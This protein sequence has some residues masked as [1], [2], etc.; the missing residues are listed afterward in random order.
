MNDPKIQKS[1]YSPY[2]SF[3][4]FWYFEKK[5]RN[6]REAAITPSKLT[7]ITTVRLPE[8]SSSNNIYSQTTSS[9]V[10]KRKP[11]VNFS[12]IAGSAYQRVPVQA[13]ILFP[14]Q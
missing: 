6:I 4:V 2:E 9:S 1:D 7:I 3:N 5:K 13:A 8:N 10:A 12:I 14:K 11:M